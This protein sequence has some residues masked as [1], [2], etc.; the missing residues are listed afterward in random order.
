[1]E[2]KILIFLIV[3]REKR[4]AIPG[5]TNAPTRVRAALC[6]PQPTLHFDFV[7]LLPGDY[8]A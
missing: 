6:I 5:M 7:Q 4:T 1:M 8:G 3:E 2:P